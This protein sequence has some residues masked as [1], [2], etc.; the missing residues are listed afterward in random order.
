MTS[1]KHHRVLVVAPTG[2]DAQLLCD[3]LGNNGI[4]G[5]RSASVRELCEKFRDGAGALLLTEEALV[6]GALEH[7][8]NALGA[9]PK[10]S[11]VPVILLSSNGLRIDA[12]ARET[13]RKNGARGDLVIVEKPVL[14]VSLRSVVDAALMTRARQY[15]MRDYLDQRNLTEAALRESE[16]RNR[17][18][19]ERVRDYAI[20]TLDSEGRV[21]GWNQGAERIKG[22]SPEEIIGEHFSRFYAAE[23]IEQGKPDL[24]LKIAAQ[25]GRCESDG[26]RVRKN[27][28]R[29]FANVVITAL[30]DEAGRT[31]GFLKVTRDITERRQAELELRRSESHLAEAEKLSHTGSWGWNVSTGE[32]FWSLEHFRICGVT[33]ETFKPTLETAGQLIHPDDREAANQAF[34]TA[35]REK[36]DFEWSFRF[37]RP[38]GTIRFVHSLAHP[39]LNASGEV[40][41]YVGTVIDDTERQHAQDKLKESE[42]RFRQL[43]EAIPHHVWSFR[44]DGTLGYWNQRL[45]DYTGLPPE[46]LAKGRWESLHPDDLERAKAAWQEAWSQGTPFEREQRLRGRDGGYRRFLCRGVPVPN[47]RGEL[48]EWFGTDTDIEERRQAEETLQEAQAELAHMTRVTV[49]GELAASIAHEVNQPLGAIVTDGGACLEWLSGEHPNIAEARAAAAR[50]IEEGIRASEVISRI[51]ALMKKDSPQMVTV[52]MNEVIREVLIL[53]RREIVRHDISLRT[54]LAADLFPTRGDNIQLRQVLVNMIV[55]AIESIATKGNEPREMLVTSQN[56]GVDQILIAVRDSG[57]GI[58]HTTVE[59]LFK[60]FVTNKREGIGMG[61]AISRSIIESC[62]GRLWAAP[63]EGGG[64]T[65]QFSLPAVKQT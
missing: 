5:Q 15:E 18:L 43:I 26:W 7:L 19:I 55:N 11:E 28:T 29:F 62:G 35:I 41:E 61:L 23:D 56:H 37:V 54:N 51:R 32:V 6:P 27:A 9:Q 12:A 22:Y 47:A 30:A 36:R 25:E 20:I 39:V 64:A 46:E 42:R 45:V 17:L 38:D 63:N 4:V 52:D 65:F 21:T 14:P 2:R 49:M 24:H 50:I 60:P 13:F 10:W 57:V 8:S 48:L 33:T 31:Y 44:K 3:V 1:D 40:T 58:D 53:V 59:E 34:Y 16:E